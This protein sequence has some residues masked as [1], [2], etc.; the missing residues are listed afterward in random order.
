MSRETLSA[1]NLKAIY[2]VPRTCPR[3]PVAPEAPGLSFDPIAHAGGP[4]HLNFFTSDVRISDRG[5]SKPIRDDA[6]LAL[7][8]GAGKPCDRPVFGRGKRMRSRAL[9]DHGGGNGLPGDQDG[10]SERAPPQRTHRQPSTQFSGC[11]D[12]GKD[13]R[14]V[15]GP[16]L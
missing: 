2:S 4:V 13:G 7:S 5:R 15:E 9:G 10:T 11:P 1:D 6:D 8:L 14:Q 3:R 16:P 12:I